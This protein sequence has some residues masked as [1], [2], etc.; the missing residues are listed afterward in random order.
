MDEV[1]RL[2]QALG[3]IDSRT[4]A[5]MAAMARNEIGTFA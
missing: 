1:I 2:A 5:A 3:A 4:F